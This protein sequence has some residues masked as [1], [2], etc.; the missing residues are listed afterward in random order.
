MASFT[1]K[2]PPMFDRKVDNYEKWKVKLD[3]WR[4]VTEVPA[5]K[6]GSLIALRLDDDTQGKVLEKVAENDLKSATGAKSVLDVLDTLFQ[7]EKSVTAYETY[8]DFESYKR[9]ET[10]S[11]KDF[12]S[13]FQS[14]LKKVQE[15]GSTLADHVLAYRLL[16]SANLSAPDLRLIKA[17]IDEMTY[18]NISKQLQKVFPDGDS[19][20]AS[21]VR[22]KEEPTRVRIKEEP[23]DI[24]EL[25]TMYG[26]SYRRYDKA[27]RSDYKDRNVK[28]DDYSPEEKQGIYKKNRGKNPLDKYGN[29]SR[30]LECDSV[31][32]QVKDC[33]DL[34]KKS[35]KTYHQDYNQLSNSEG[36]HRGNTAGIE[37][38]IDQCAVVNDQYE[39]L[40]KITLTCDSLN[41]ALLDC[42]A[43]KTVCGKKWLNEYIST[44]SQDDR[45]AVEYNKS[46]NMY[47]FGCGNKLPALEHVG[48]P[49]MIGESKVIIGT[50]VVEGDIPLL[51]SRESMKKCGSNLNFRDDTL[52]IFGQKL[53]L[54][55]TESGHYA[56]P[57]GRNKQVMVD[58]AREDV[59]VTL[60]V[61]N[62]DSMK[63][64]F[65]LHQMFVHPSADRL[66]NLVENQGKDCSDLVT[67]INKVSKKCKIC[68]VYRKP[69]VGFPM[70]TTGHMTYYNVAKQF[71]KVFYN[72]EVGMKEG[73]GVHSP[74][75][76]FC[77]AK[78]AGSD[79]TE[80]GHVSCT[81]KETRSV[82]FTDSAEDE[83]MG[84]RYKVTYNSIIEEPCDQGNES[85]Y[86]EDKENVPYT[87]AGVGDSAGLT[88]GI[89]VANEMEL[90]ELCIDIKPASQ[91]DDNVVNGKDQNGAES[92]DTY[93]D[94]DQKEVIDSC[95]SK[96]THRL[97]QLRRFRDIRSTCCFTSLP[98]THRHI[99]SKVRSPTSK[100]YKS[101][102][103]GMRLA[104]S[105][106][107]SDFNGK[108][109]ELRLMKRVWKKKK[110]KTCLYECHKIQKKTGKKM[111][112]YKG[113]RCVTV[114]KML[115]RRDETWKRK[116]GLCKPQIKQEKWSWKRKK[117]KCSSYQCHG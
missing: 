20:Q 97:R 18:Q 17:T 10:L 63:V 116:R 52:E 3:L 66:N 72:C 85:K 40:T 11:M 49:A 39:D 76:T 104:E 21:R 88:K 26:G 29:V 110:V 91:R 113:S 82:T 95:N 15:A 94:K 101:G 28:K 117:K 83:A 44:L 81:A 107:T 79:D 24:V 64:A 80:V 87:A 16:N 77:G 102:T 112:I 38:V 14:K 69:V 47:R 106:H 62:D 115:Y 103:H 43:P 58:V 75:D 45:R 33:P 99:P 92:G 73:P 31:N 22:I 109:T 98:C 27:K 8:E 55:V 12:I 84:S 57:L 48:I 5:T 67:A 56:L 70:A 111:V 7:V 96:K 4:T 42:G 68:A 93:C 114:N 9:P 90:E 30:C 13:E 53:N 19:N 35:H 50:D 108:G 23:T 89:E 2:T 34:V 61:K 65:Q 100:R 60:F 86:C 32:H 37:Y 1:D 105:K 59:K 46:N 36:D 51:F 71:K 74:S 54:V 78:Y 25:D 6:H 41:T